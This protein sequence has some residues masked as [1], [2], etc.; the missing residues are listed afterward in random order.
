MKVCE[1]EIGT[2]KEKCNGGIGEKGMQYYQDTLQQMWGR[3]F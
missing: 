3:S 2:R 1:K